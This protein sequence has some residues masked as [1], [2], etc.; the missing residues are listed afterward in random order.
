MGTKDHLNMEERPTP[1]PPR[2]VILGVGGAGGNAVNNMIRSGL[3]GVEFVVANTDAQALSQSE[4]EVCIQLGRGVTK[5]LGAG[6]QPE[7]GRVAAEETLEEIV[8]HLEGAN[9]LFITAGM[10]G[11]TGTGAAPVIAQAAREAGVLTVGVVTKPFDF[12]GMHRQRLA[13]AGITE[14]TQH[15]DTLIIIP[16]QNLFRLADDKT[17]FADAFRMADDVLHAGVR[18]VTDLMVVPGLINL[19]FMDIRSVMTEMGKAMMGTGEAEGDDRA[20]AAAEA[21]ISNPLLD[22]VSMKGARG[23]LINI[24]GGL[25]LTLFEVDQAANRIREEVAPEANIIFGSTLN[26]SLEGKMRV[27]VVA[28]GIGVDEGTRAVPLS[29]IVSKGAGRALSGS[30]PSNRESQSKPGKEEQGSEPD[31]EDEPATTEPAARSETGGLDSQGQGGQAAESP[32][33][34]NDGNGED[35]LTLEPV[36]EAPASAADS[37]LTRDFDDSDDDGS[38]TPE[39]KS[40]ATPLKPLFAKGAEGVLMFSKR[41]QKAADETEP[42]RKAS[43]SSETST[44]SLEKDDSRD[45]AD[46]GQGSPFSLIHG[47]KSEAEEDVSEKDRKPDSSPAETEGAVEDET[48]AGLMGEGDEPAARDESG[49]ETENGSA[50]EST[51][52]DRRA[53]DDFSDED[54]SEEATV[55]ETDAED[56]D[57]KEM[58]PLPLALAAE[59]VD[60]AESTGEADSDA[61]PTPEKVEKKRGFLSWMTSGGSQSAEDYFAKGDRYYYG[62]DGRRD[63]ALAIRAYRK[64]AEM[65]HAAAQNRLGWIYEKGEGVPEDVAEAVKWY[66]KS[67]E[68]GYVNAMN[69]LGYL[70]RE[71]CGVDQDYEAAL[72]WFGKAAAKYDAYAEY[73]MGQMY[74]NGW[75]VDK[76]EEEAV[77]WFRR[78]AARGHE[79]A[80]KRLEELGVET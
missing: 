63:L 6:S 47:S 80:S 62:T 74:E 2:I 38:A 73:N 15:V 71:G 43:E 76:D 26:E 66:R 70:Y 9:M 13:D 52:A 46:A 64:A 4:C 50:R 25:D 16:N 3:S 21:A 36:G 10:G 35:A 11:G 7:I 56:G 32:Y 19:D 34:E 22:D 48:P 17:T 20:V 54:A 67:A 37:I 14:L 41:G 68:Q 23:V 65:N 44:G 28:T 57:E 59:R 27:S 45:R 55:Q 1:Q 5:G 58:P 69:D 79:W 40:A 8:S 42:D 77:R 51:E 18:G 75:G 24:T 60:Q 29:L 49:G 39:K 72:E 78:A 30:A 53:D 12:E 31:S 61:P 33:L